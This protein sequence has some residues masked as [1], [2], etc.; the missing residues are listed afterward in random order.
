MKD[1]IVIVLLGGQYTFW[2]VDW[3]FKLGLGIQT[4][5]ICWTL[6]CVTI[7]TREIKIPMVQKV[8]IHKKS[9]GTF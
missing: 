4:A 7:M 3:K 8:M 2:H 5:S 6:S 9:H 1:F